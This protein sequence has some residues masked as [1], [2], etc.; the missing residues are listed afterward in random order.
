MIKG[1]NSKLKSLSIFKK[2]HKILVWF[3]HSSVVS[4]SFAMGG[5]EYSFL[6][7][8]K[9]RENLTNLSFSLLFEHKLTNNEKYLKSKSE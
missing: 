8:C 1:S 3:G 7:K 2:I 6:Q 5:K 4:W 9:V